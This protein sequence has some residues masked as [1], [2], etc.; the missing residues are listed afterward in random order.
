MDTL[1]WVTP[2]YKENLVTTDYYNGYML[3]HDT[4]TETNYAGGPVADQS[5]HLLTSRLT[6]LF[7]MET[8]NVSL[9]GFYSPNE[10]D[11]YGRGAVTYKYTDEVS[12]A[13]GTNLFHG[14]HQYTTFGAFERNDNVY[15][16]FTY[17]I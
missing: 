7:M 12:V 8:L 13:L 3:D 16:K 17:G 4:Y 14:E 10:E 2:I 6:M 1:P 15:L 5:Y 11:A 9:F